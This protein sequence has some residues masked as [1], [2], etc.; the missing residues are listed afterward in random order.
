MEETRHQHDRDD[1]QAMILVELWVP[2][3]SSTSYGARIRVLPVTSALSSL[4]SPKEFC[5]CL[6][7]LNWDGQCRLHLHI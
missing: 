6:I 2:V 7:F 1:H 4:T 3:S 5:C